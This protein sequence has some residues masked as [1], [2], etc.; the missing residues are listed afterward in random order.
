[1]E[2]ITAGDGTAHVSSADD[3][4]IYAGIAGNECYVTGVGDRLSCTMQGAN[5][6][7]V[8]TGVGI[9]YGRAFRVAMPEE[10]TIQSGTQ[11]QRRNDVI[12]AHFTTS[13]EGHESGELVVLKGTPTSGQE[14]EDPEIPSGDILEGA[15]EAYMPLWRIPLDG[16]NVGEP[17]AMFD[18]LMSMSELQ[19]EI[20]E[21]RDSVSQNAADIDSL[22]TSVSRKLDA[23]RVLVGSKVISLKAMP[24]ADQWVAYDDLLTAS[25][26]RSML[27]RNF[28]GAADA[29]AVWNG[30]WNA[31]N[32]LAVPF[33]RT[34][35]TSAGGNVGVYLTSAV[36]WPGSGRPGSVRVGYMVVRGN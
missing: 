23:S 31:A 17:E 25:E 11:S 32:V 33:A 1:M 24:G 21:V 3:G 13:S 12:C 5:T 27:G 34:S 28:N 36:D 20:A 9:M 4:T 19:G 15:T 35:T 2:I 18:V 30:D 29:V 14:A 8:G 16:I 22:A 26:L 6:A 7:L 10:V